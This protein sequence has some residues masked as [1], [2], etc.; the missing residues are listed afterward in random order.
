MLGEKAEALQMSTS[1]PDLPGAVPRREQ[2]L[3][4]TSWSKGEER[5]HMGLLSFK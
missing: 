4:K 3:I 1:L 5:L 2:A